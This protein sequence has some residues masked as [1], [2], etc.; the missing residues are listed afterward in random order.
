[1]QRLLP[2]AQVKNDHEALQG[3]FAAVN[4]RRVWFGACLNPRNKL[5]S[6]IS[7]KSRTDYPETNTY[8]VIW[9]LF[10]FLLSLLLIKHQTDSKAGKG[11]LVFCNSSK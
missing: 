1:M 7:E 2:P 9:V 4:F 5:K 11:T 3:Y 8:Y 10:F 6:L